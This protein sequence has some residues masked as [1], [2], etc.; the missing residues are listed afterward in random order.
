MINYSW[1]RD[2]NPNGRIYTFE[3]SDKKCQDHGNF[4]EQ[5]LYD[6]VN[7]ENTRKEI[8]LQFTWDSIPSLAK[9]IVDEHGKVIGNG[10]RDDLQFGYYFD[11]VAPNRILNLT[12]SD[13]LNDN[14]KKTIQSRFP[15]KVQVL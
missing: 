6:T 13:E 3:G 10:K 4:M 7:E 15:G 9:K 12:F 5:D 14:D 2:S 11:G 1:D 8:T